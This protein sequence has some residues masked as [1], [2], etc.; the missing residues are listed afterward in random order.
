MSAHRKCI[1]NF[2]EEK[3]VYFLCYGRFLFSY[4][5]RSIRKSVKRE[6]KKP[7]ENMHYAQLHK[8]FLFPVCMDG[9]TCARIKH[10]NMTE[11]QVCI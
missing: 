6:K 5:K 1:Y 4:L 8:I 10:N 7:T 9:R 2:D 11:S 3:I